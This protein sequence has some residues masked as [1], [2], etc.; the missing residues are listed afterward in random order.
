M[1]ELSLGS[2]FVGLLILGAGIA[3]VKWH[4]WVADNFG[5]GYSSYD[6]YKLAALI[7]CAAGFIVMVNLH[8]VILQWLAHAILP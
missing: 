3:F 8:S 6:R 5:S 1:Y 2:F 4:Q 7:T